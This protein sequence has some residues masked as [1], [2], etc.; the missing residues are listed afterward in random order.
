MSLKKLPYFLLVKKQAQEVF[1]TGAPGIIPGHSKPTLFLEKIE[2]DDLT[3]SLF[4]K[5]GYVY[6]FRVKIFPDRFLPATIFSRASFNSR[7]RARYF[8]K[9]SLVTFSILKASSRAFKVGC[10]AVILQESD[11]PGLG[12]MAVFIQA[13]DKRKSSGR[14][15]LLSGTD[16]P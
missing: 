8:S 12:G 7:N 9:N 4:G 14:G 10:R 5:V 6:A 15:Q 1:G 3:Q 16:F 13:D 11:Q 2:E